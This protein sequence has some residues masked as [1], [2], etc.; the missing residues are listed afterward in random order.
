MADKDLSP[1]RAAE[2]LS[3]EPETGRLVWLANTGKKAVNQVGAS[4]GS[5]NAKSGYVVVSIFGKRYQAHRLAW[6]LMTG[7]WPDG[8]VDHID[9]NRANNR[10]SN[11]RA[12]SRSVNA[13][14]QRHPQRNNKSGFLGVHAYRGKF[15]AVIRVAGRKSPVQIGAYATAEEAHQAYL[16]AKRRLHQGCTL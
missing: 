12:V 2:L 3:Y 16:K 8:E 4:A 9:G 10:W 5:K 6:A 11:L 13:Q 14:N 1:L 7:S 15:R